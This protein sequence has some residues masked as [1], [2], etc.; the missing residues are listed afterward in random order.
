[1][2]YALISIKLSAQKNGYWNG[3]GE[4]AVRYRPCHKKDINVMR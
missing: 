1:M 3:H 2:Q 4:T